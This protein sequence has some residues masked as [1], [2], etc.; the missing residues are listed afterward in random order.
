MGISRFRVLH[1]MYFSFETEVK[2]TFSSLAGFFG[3]TVKHW[4]KRAHTHDSIKHIKCDAKSLPGP[5]HR[6]PEQLQ[7]LEHRIT[8]D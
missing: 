5:C 8:M 1:D 7:R 4:T 6:G 3:A 2:R